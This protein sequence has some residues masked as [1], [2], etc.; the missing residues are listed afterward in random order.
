MALVQR[1]VHDSSYAEIAARLGC[2][3]AAARVSVYKT[4]RTLR[5]HLGDRV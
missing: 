4:L 1:L 3:E 5:D 2:S